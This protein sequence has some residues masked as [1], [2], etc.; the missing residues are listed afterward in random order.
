[1]RGAIGGTLGALGGTLIPDGPGG[2][3]K[4]GGYLGSK[5]GG[6]IG[7]KFDKKKPV[8]E[9][10]TQID[11]L[12]NPNINLPFGGDLGSLITMV[13]RRR[14]WWSC[15]L[16]SEAAPIPPTERRRKKKKKKRKNKKKKRKNNPKQPMRHITQLFLGTA[17]ILGGCW[18]FWLSG[19]PNLLEIKMFQR[20]NEEKE[21]EEEEEEKKN[22]P[23]AV[24]KVTR[25]RVRRPCS[26]SRYPNCVKK[27]AHEGR[28]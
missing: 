15:A 9:D 12:I 20:R 22:L 19:G 6:F 3:Q 1:M 27:K 17:R 8:K 14:S 21:K 2:G 13:G 28:G 5:V 10:L 11:E 26:E 25:R 16:V 23:E 24:G 4:F 7:K 18:W